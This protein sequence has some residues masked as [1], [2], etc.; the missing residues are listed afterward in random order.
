M[1]IAAPPHKHAK[2]FVDH[3][4]NL[5]VTPIDRRGTNLI[6]DF[7]VFRSYIQIIRNCNPDIVL[8]YTIKPNVYGGLVCSLLNVPYLANITGLGTS[9]ENKG[10]LRTIST[11]LYKLGLRK[12]SCVFFQ[13]ETNRDFFMRKKLLKT[14]S[15]LIPGSG[16]NLREHAFE[17]YPN[18]EH[19]IGLLFIGRV[20][21]AKG[22]DELLQAA[23]RIT[24][25]YPDVKFDLVGACEEEYSQVLQKLGERHVIQYHGRQADVHSYVKKSHATINPSYHEGMSNVLLESAAAGR[26]VLATNVPGCRETF[27]EG[28]SGLSFEPKS[29]DSLIEAIEKFIALPWEKKQEMGLFGRKKMEKEFNR[30]IVVNAYLEEICKVVR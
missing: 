30:N 1:V 14:K 6:A 7:K 11:L 26:P 18:E 24:E 20:M 2:F 5:I 21:K 4:C 8:T 23:E 17:D 9:I 13:N 15:R 16:V 10:L 25:K 29:T 28:L 12:A 27:D 22:I 3:G 19:G